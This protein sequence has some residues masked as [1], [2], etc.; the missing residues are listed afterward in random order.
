MKKIYFVYLLFAAIS[1]ASCSEEEVTPISMNEESDKEIVRNI[2]LSYL[3]LQEDLGSYNNA[4]MSK[5]GV[6]QTRSG[7]GDWW[8]RKWRAISKADATGALQGYKKGYGWCS[9]LLEGVVYSAAA[10]FEIDLDDAIVPILSN[11]PLGEDV[12]ICSGPDLGGVQRPIEILP[13]GEISVN[14]YVVVTNQGVGYLH[15]QILSKIDEDTPN[16][17]NSHVSINSMTETIIDEM[18]DYNYTVPQ[19][20]KTSII[21]ETNLVFENIDEVKNGDVTTYFQ[22]L[23][24]EDAN[25][26]DIIDD[27]VDSVTLLTNMA[28]IQ[29]YLSGYLQTIQ[30]SNLTN[31]EK[32]KLTIAIEVAA[33]SSVLWEV[34]ETSE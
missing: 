12:S 24:P 18:E 23:F 7:F 1:V 30:N 17:F 11:N 9:C 34:Q 20:L 19:S 16:I 25:D 29:S 2:P 26:L 32:E 27:F 14:H 5:N 10:V 6:A 4:F 3:C 8:R 13:E 22:T 15:N 31:E 28:D 21:N 33:N